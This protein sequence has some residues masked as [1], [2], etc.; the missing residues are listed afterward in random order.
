MPRSQGLRAV[1]YMEFHEGHQGAMDRLGGLPTHLPPAFPTD[2]AAG[3]LGFVGQFYSHPERL[4]LGGARCI[5]IYQSV[6]IDGGGDPTPRGV[7]VPA[8]APTNTSNQ[9]LRHPSLSPVDIEWRCATE[10]ESADEG[11]D[12][13][14]QGHPPFPPAAGETFVG[15]LTEIAECPGLNFGTFTAVFWMTKGG[16]RVDLL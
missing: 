4:P 3:Q 10:S 6:D 1:W 14:L 15:Q 9:G 13:K 2:S 5:Q 12:P 8:H 16:L 11:A 7:L